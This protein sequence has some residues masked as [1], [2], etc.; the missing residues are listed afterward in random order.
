MM[1]SQDNGSGRTDEGLQVR[2][3]NPVVQA[4]FAQAPIP[5]VRNA[6]LSAAARLLYI[7]LTSYAWTD[8]S[9]Y[10]GQERLAADLGV[11]SRMVRTYLAE[12][13][14]AGLLT[15]SRR[16]MGQTNLYILEDPPPEAGFLSEDRPEAHFRIDRKP[17]SGPIKNEEVD[18]V[19]EDADSPPDPDDLTQTIWD[20]YVRLSNSRKKTLEP[21]HRQVIEKA[22]EVAT[23]RECCQAIRAL[24]NS[25]FHQK[26]GKYEN[27]PGQKYRAIT[28]A[29]RGRP[30]NGETTEQRIAGWVEADNQR[31]ATLK[32]ETDFFGEHEETEPEEVPDDFFGAFTRDGKQRNP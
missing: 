24:F 10:P 17:T 3:R 12:L 21:V 28:D 5:I 2:F 4:G 8:G 19:N 29:L 23:A 25:D 31:I 14:K 16:G 18:A 9:C 26:R 11:S 20:F 1:R 30:R 27:R 32:A 7:T 15:V 22:L 13:T 6:D